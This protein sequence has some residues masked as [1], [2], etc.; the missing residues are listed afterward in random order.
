VT[1]VEQKLSQA[2]HELV[3][4]PPADV[5]IDAVARTARR[6]RR[7]GAAAMA[8]VASALIAAVTVPSV[9]LA[10]ERTGSTVGASSSGVSLTQRSSWD[11]VVFRYPAGWQVRSFPFATHGP[12]R[13]GPFLGNQAL[14]GPCWSLPQRGCGLADAVQGLRAGGVIAEW[15]SFTSRDASSVLPGPPN[16]TVDGRPARVTISDASAYC[17]AMGGTITLSAV[18]VGGPSDQGYALTAC[19]RGPGEA[20]TTATLRAVIAAARFPATHSDVPN[21]LGLSYSSA[22]KELTLL[23]YAARAVTVPGSAPSGRV[24]AQ[25]PAAGSYE[26]VGGVVQLQVVG[27]TPTEGPGTPAAVWRAALNLSQHAVQPH[28]AATAVWTETTWGQWW[29]LE[30]QPTQPS[31]ASAQQVFVVELVSATPM[32]CFVCTNVGPEPTGRY[33]YSTFAVDGSGGGGFALGDVAYRLSAIGTVRVAGTG[34]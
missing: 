10:A 31:P 3:P 24:V 6:R 20:Q 26:P 28:P 11:G 13:P 21:V 16:M 30:G 12:G 18:I 29:R 33:A 27:G 7:A 4:Q 19:S 25:S 14:D 23:G 9:L 2:L 17:R 15:S 32:T 5:S 1:P 22:V 34:L 8:L